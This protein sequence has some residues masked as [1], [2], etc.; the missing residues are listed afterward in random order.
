LDDICVLDCEGISD[1]M[2][3]LFGS[4]LPFACLVVLYVI[5]LLL[6][7]SSIYWW[8]Q[9]R[10]ILV[11]NRG[12]MIPL[13]SLHGLVFIFLMVFSLGLW[14]MYLFVFWFL[15]ILLDF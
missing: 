10:E 6:R 8:K 1:C 15:Y 7:W 3:N 5:L 12:D 2:I 11:V 4:S 9:M 14:P 13:L